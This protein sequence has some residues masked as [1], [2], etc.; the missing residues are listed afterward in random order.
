MTEKRRPSVE[1]EALERY[2]K[3]QPSIFVGEAEQDQK[4]KVWLESLEDIF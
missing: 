1:D 4:A 3:F 2:L